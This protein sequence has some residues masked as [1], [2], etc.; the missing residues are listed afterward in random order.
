MSTDL[1]DV[2][3]ALTL[4]AAPQ[5]ELAAP[6]ALDLD[7]LVL[8]TFHKPYHHNPA[9]TWVR[10]VTVGRF[11]MPDT[12]G[13]FSDAS[14][15]DHISHLNPQ[16]CELTAL[17]WAWKNLRGVRHIG[18]YH[19]R[20]YLYLGGG[21]IPGQRVPVTDIP[22][23]INAMSGPE[24][25]AR[26]LDWLQHADAIVP[27]AFRLGGSITQE[28]TLHHDAEHWRVFNEVLFELNPQYRRFAGYFAQS[29]K[30]TYCNMF[31]VGWAR[32][33][34][35][36]ATMFPV[37]FEVQRR[38]PVPSDPYQARYIGFLAERFLMFYLYAEGLRTMETP[39]VGM[40]PGA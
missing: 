11:R 20:R 5:T 15:A 32:F 33:E 3:D 35:Y 39:I 18:L 29:N 37:L 21:F 30:F 4:D 16:F 27:S 23:S 2:A 6:P 25:G 10:P 17:Y 36:C 31:I 8:T 24:A 12:P 1:A 7:L 34:H 22:A 28:Y 26:A 19:Y 13:V 40:E 14:G 9:S 38:C